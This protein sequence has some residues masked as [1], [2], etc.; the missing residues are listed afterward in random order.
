M[1]ALK[2]ATD[3]EAI[4]NVVQQGFGAIGNDTPIGPL[5][6][7]YFDPAL[8]PPTVDI[9]G[10]KALLAEEKVGRVLDCFSV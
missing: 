2:M 9:E 1:Q 7:S 4:F 3:R 6:E 5:Y 8:I 10:G